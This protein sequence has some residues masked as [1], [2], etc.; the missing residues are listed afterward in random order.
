MELWTV[1][2][3][4]L[5]VVQSGKVRVRSSATWHWRAL[6]S[7]CSESQQNVLV[8][9]CV[10]I[11]VC[12]RAE[13]RRTGRGRGRGSHA[14]CRHPAVSVR[15]YASERTLVVARRRPLACRALRLRW[16]LRLK[17]RP[18]L[19]RTRS[20]HSYTRTRSRTRRVAAHGTYRYW[21]VE[22]LVDDYSRLD[23]HSYV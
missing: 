21:F 17:Q 12:V 6:Y 5:L 19:E 11:C 4:L 22:R 18:S 7:R 8:F 13:L 16:R 14:E 15:P 10:C 23:V 20:V 3:L 1:A 9:V 2:S